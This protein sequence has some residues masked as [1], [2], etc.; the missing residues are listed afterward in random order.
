MQ[1][2]MFRQLFYSKYQWFNRL[3]EQIKN[4]YRRD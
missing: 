3:I 1:I 2:F 4:D